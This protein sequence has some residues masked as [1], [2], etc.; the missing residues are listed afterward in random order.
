MDC[1]QY[2]QKYFFGWREYSYIRHYW[3]D[4]LFSSRYRLAC[5]CCRRTEVLEMDRGHGYDDVFD[6]G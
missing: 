2:H 3:R 6:P 1:G 4:Y 5:A